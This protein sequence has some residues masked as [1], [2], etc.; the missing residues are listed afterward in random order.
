MLILDWDHFQITKRH[1]VVGGS[2]YLIITG[3]LIVSWSIPQT[4]FWS[5][6]Q[7][8]CQISETTLVNVTTCQP[9]CQCNET[10]LQL[11]P[12]TPSCNDTT[13]NGT[14]CDNGY[15][16][17]SIN[18]DQCTVC[19]E[20]KCYSYSCNC[21]CNQVVVHDYCTQICTLQ[22]E[23]NCTTTF[24]TWGVFPSCVVGDWFR[25]SILDNTILTNTNNFPWTYWGVPGILLGS[26]IIIGGCW[27]RIQSP[28]VI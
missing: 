25:C 5:R 6:D 26:I 7:Q 24:G 23:M 19:T 18:C 10:P 4:V 27:W 28:G 17:C 20:L 9:S 22:Q 8:P 15:S 1:V 3:L 11:L 12:T 14:L 13:V 16:C 21:V 2:I